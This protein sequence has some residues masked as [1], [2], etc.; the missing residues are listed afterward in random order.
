MA[1]T[2][3]SYGFTALPADQSLQNPKTTSPGPMDTSSL[4][5]PRTP[6]ATR[7][8]AYAKAKLDVDTYRHSLRVY[9]YG[10]AIARQCF[11]EY[12]L[13]PGS[14]LEETWF[15]TAM[16]HDIGT[17]TEFL[18]S[19]QLSFEFWGAYHALQ[20]LQDP[21]MTGGEGVA[22]REQAESV[23]EAIIRHQ[24]IQDEGK[25]TLI[26]RL[27]H[28]GTLLD[29]IGAGPE[30]VHPETIENVVHEYPRPGWSG[31]FKKTVEKEKAVKPYAMVSRIQGFEEMIQKNGASGGLMAKYD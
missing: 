23:T 24:D 29:N 2:A 7:V 5:P 4:Q 15:L 28:L 18:T 1:N 21:T 3:K 14:D 13:A 27:I 17:S 25:I 12:E 11:P 6:L 22:P 9:S 10:C 31:C 30:L 20:L 8:A 26:T 19:T 16:L